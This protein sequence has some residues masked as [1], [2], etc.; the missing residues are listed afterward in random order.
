VEGS[1][2][3]EVC[4]AI[5]DFAFVPGQLVFS[6]DWLKLP[7]MH[8]GFMIIEPASTRGVFA[9]QDGYSGLDILWSIFI[10]GLWECS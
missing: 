10:G 6:S 4:R 7:V 5:V 1:T 3:E 2:E 8:S 9:L